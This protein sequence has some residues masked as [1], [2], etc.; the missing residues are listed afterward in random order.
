MSND[1]FKFTAVKMGTPYDN[2]AAALGILQQAVLSLR[3][4]FIGTVDSARWEA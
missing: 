1:I 3:M 2:L 4:P